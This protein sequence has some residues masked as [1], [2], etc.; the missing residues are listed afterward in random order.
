MLTIVSTGS[1]G[2]HISADFLS[3]SRHDPM[4]WGRVCLVYKAGCGSARFVGMKVPRTMQSMPVCSAGRRR[5]VDAM[6]E[7]TYRT[8]TVVLMVLAIVVTVLVA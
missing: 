2:R 4:K 1:I 5:K 3:H 6:S 7:G 8:L